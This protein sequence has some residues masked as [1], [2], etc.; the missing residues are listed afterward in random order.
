M[1]CCCRPPPRQPLESAQQFVLLHTWSEHRQYAG[2]RTIF[3]KIGLI[4]KRKGRTDPPFCMM[5]LP[6]SM[7]GAKKITDFG[8]FFSKL[9]QR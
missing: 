9:N 6:F 2:S 7:S 8:R 1:G 5:N 4:Y 3:Q